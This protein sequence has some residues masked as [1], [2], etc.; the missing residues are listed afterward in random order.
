MRTDIHMAKFP[1]P[2]MERKEQPKG[3]FSRHLDVLRGAKKKK[4]KRE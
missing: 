4:K 1:L 3:G 2:V